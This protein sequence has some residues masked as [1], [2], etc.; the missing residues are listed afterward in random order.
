MAATALLAD[1]VIKE[2]WKWGDPVNIEG[3]DYA[4]GENESLIANT[5]HSPIS[6]K[7]IMACLRNHPRAD[8]FFLKTISTDDN[9]YTVKKNVVNSPSGSLFNFSASL[10]ELKQ[11]PQDPEWKDK[12][13]REQEAYPSDERRAEV[14]ELARDM[15]LSAISDG[16]DLRQ[17]KNTNFALL[18]DGFYKHID[19]HFDK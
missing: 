10:D 11:A 3:W 12:G 8:E 2:S 15:F 7:G 4:E 9:T 14:T 18:A 17:V 13:E 5:F 6:E 16:M 19:K 1:R